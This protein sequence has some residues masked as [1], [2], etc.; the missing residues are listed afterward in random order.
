MALKLTAKMSRKSIFFNVTIHSTYVLFSTCEHGITN[1]R[2]F[3]AFYTDHKQNIIIFSRLHCCNC[4]LVNSIAPTR[5]SNIVIV[6][7]ETV[8]PFFDKTSGDMHLS[9]H[10]HTQTPELILARIQCVPGGGLFRRWENGICVK[11]TIHHIFLLNN[12]YFPDF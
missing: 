12:F 7:S 3:Y 8:P 5:C 4:L 9:Y 6:Y 10:Y 2:F 1:S 11:L